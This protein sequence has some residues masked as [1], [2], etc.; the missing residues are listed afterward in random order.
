[1]ASL[2]VFGVGSDALRGVLVAIGGASAVVAILIWLSLLVIYTWFAK[3]SVGKIIGGRLA[4]TGFNA[5]RQ[6]WEQVWVDL[7]EYTDLDGE[8][9]TFEPRFGLKVKTFPRFAL[10][11]RSREGWI[12][13]LV[14]TDGTA[15]VD[16]FREKWTLVVVVGTPGFIALVVTFW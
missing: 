11:S 10:N 6:E 9:K 15:L 16:T 3:R 8:V 2:A 1:M 12:P 5:M 13:I 14:F 7:I 4:T